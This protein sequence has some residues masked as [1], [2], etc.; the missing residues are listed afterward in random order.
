MEL[1]PTDCQFDTVFIFMIIIWTKS[2]MIL[3]LNS[4]IGETIE[5]KWGK[6]YFISYFLIKTSPMTI[7]GAKIQVTNYV[8]S[9][10][11]NL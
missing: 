6:L 3:H 10:K 4:R 8:A 2:V 1:K 9:L 5:K 11:F 7:I